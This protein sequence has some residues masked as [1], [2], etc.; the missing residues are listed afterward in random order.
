SR[1][2]PRPRCRCT[3]GARSAKCPAATAATVS[4][5]SIIPSRAIFPPM[6]P[7]IPF[8]RYRL[9]RRL[10]RGGMAE[11]FLA[12]LHSAEGFE[13]RVAI[14][15][16]LPHLSDSEEFRAMFMDEARLAALLSHPNV[17]HIYE[18]GREG[19]HDFIAMEFVDGLSL[20]Q[21]I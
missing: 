1:A 17:V 20:A 16:I 10:A 8:G 13:R 2:A 18:F 5:S 7:G 6:P 21:M 4:S 14:K 19:E 11:V 12:R 9:L 3:M 15:R